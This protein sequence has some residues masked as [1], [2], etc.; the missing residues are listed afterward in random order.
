ML[1]THETALT[2]QQRINKNLGFAFQ[3]YSEVCYYIDGF[4]RVTRQ[5]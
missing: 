1:K 3:F 4:V 5:F 2:A